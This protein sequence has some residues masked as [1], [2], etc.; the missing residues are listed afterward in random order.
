MK[1]SFLKKLLITFSIALLSY[2]FI[3]ACAFD[4]WGWFGYSSFAPEPFADKSYSPL[5]YDQNSMFYGIGYDYNYTNRFNDEILTDWAG[6]LGNTISKPHLSYFLLNDSSKEEIEN[7]YAYC[8]KKTKSK[9]I[10]AWS[11]KINL[12]NQKTSDFFE[13]LH[14]AKLVENSS[15]SLF[16]PWSYEEAAGPA[17]V[18]DKILSWLQ[19]KYQSVADP[20]LKN[21]YWFQYV[22]ALFYSESKQK[23]ITFF[24]QTKSSVPK[25]TLYYRALSY[26]AG[27]HNKS[28]QFAQA[29]YEY[30]IVF[31]NCP[32]LRLSAAYNFHPQEEADWQKSLQMASSSDEKAALWAMLGYYADP[33][34]AIDEIYKLN[35]KNKHLDYLLTRYINKEEEKIQTGIKQSVSAYKSEVKNKL[36]VEGLNLVNSI[37]SSDKTGKPFLWN[38]AAGYLQILNSDFSNAKDLLSKAEKQIPNEISVRDQLQLLKL[39]LS[40][41][42]TNAINTANENKLLPQLKW[43]FAK[44]AKQDNGSLRYDAAVDLCKK[45]ISAL[46]HEVNNVVMA[47][48]FNPNIEFYHDMDRLEVMKGFILKSDK[49]EFESLAKQIYNINLSDIY[50]FEAILNTF[51][52]N[53]EFAWESMNN[54]DVLKDQLL[55]GNPFNGKIQ[56]CHDCDHLAVQKTKYSKLRFV[57]IIKIMQEKTAKGEDL[58]NNYLLLGNAFYNISYYGNARFF[59]NTKII[60][61]YDQFYN[62]MIFDNSIAKE[63]YQKAFDAAA[64]DEQRAKCSYM[65]A[66]CERNEY[67]NANPA[68]EESYGDNALPSFLAWGGFIGLKT[69]YAS[70]KFY[71]EV[72]NE[73][74]YFKTYLRTN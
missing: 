58:Y 1:T 56:D 33:V 40:I 69:K 39:I 62:R 16:D 68:I 59:Y 10:S 48:M 6:F 47:E 63:Y 41:Y 35:P 23:L 14:Y 27:I 70:T 45:Y 61:Y 17:P 38:M 37:A 18:N 51:K 49:T 72:I 66:K 73:C 74:G 30:S 54:A 55:P 53:M 24:D 8:S 21:R 42:E 65:L 19:N 13:F 28:K 50:E 11:G 36:N 3:L 31:N 29:N 67:Y 52:N 43:L 32:P 26:V 71:K 20:F 46:Y 5:F 64:N 12:E 7:I 57:E 34:R 15:V 60:D 2:V 9:S 4:D 44:T 25:N 22:K